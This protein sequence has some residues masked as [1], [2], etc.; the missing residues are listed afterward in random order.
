MAAQPCSECTR[1]KEC[2]RT[3]LESVTQLKSQL[4]GVKSQ[5]ESERQHVAGQ[6]KYI[7][8]L[9]GSLKS[10]A[11]DTKAQVSRPDFQDQ[12]KHY[13]LCHLFS[14]FSDVIKQFELPI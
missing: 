10:A 14:A 9:E 7:S 6:T 3:G 11:I 1:C 4:A 2:L 12:L 13:C 5:L 8:E